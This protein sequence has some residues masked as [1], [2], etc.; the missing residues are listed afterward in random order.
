MCRE[1]LDEHDDQLTQLENDIAAA[2]KAAEAEAA[3]IDDVG[4]ATPLVSE[5][6]WESRY[7]PLRN[8]GPLYLWNPHGP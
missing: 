8:F 2:K 4:P 5:K 7:R 6:V 1:A 3:D